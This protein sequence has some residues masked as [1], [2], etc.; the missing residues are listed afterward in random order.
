MADTITFHREEA[1][2]SRIN[3]FL[4]EAFALPEADYYARLDIKN[5]LRI[6]AALSDINNALT[7]RLTLQF[8]AWIQGALKLDDEAAVAVLA[9][10]LSVKPSSNGFDV[11]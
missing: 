11:F 10:V 1:L 7:L 6:K 2:R 3:A 4:R 8:V 5:L 9:S